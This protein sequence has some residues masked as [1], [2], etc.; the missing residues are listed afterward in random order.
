M[1]GK[2]KTKKI[3]VFVEK[4]KKCCNTMS[5]RIFAHVFPVAMKIYSS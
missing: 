1:Y 4:V 2:R 5:G 3:K